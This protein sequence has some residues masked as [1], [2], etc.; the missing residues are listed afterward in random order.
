MID[1]PGLV[2]FD[3]DGVL[4]DSEPVSNEV[5]AV[6]L[7]EA[8][9]PTT[10]ADSLRDYKGRLMADIVEIAQRRL[11]SPLPPGFVQEYEQAREQ[12]FRRELRP[13]PG[14][15]ET[16]AAIRA[17]GVAVCVASQGKREKTELT[18]TLTGQR[19]LFADDALFT[20]YAVA[21]GKPHPDLFLHAARTMGI[22]P[23]RSVVVE[24]TAIGTR[25]GVSA[26]MRVLGYAADGDADELRAA[27]AETVSALTEIPA[28]IGVAPAAP[29]V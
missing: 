20:A 28:L 9:L 5:L 29:P 11:G 4:V 12:A 17:A 10:A 16:V 3:C 21:R 19:H 18:L 24:D 22:P 25:A 14:A 7:T 1:L 23:Q 26:G 8:G 2:I 6:C 27:G 15:A 13:I